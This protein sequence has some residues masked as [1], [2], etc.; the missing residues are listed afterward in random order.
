[1]NVSGGAIGALQRY[2]KVTVEDLLVIVDDVD[3]PAGRLR[4]R[5]GGSAGGTTA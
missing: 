5:R 3:L 2:F 1:M 4:A